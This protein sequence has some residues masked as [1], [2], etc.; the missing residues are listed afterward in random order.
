LFDRIIHINYYQFWLKVPR[1]MKQWFPLVITRFFPSFLLHC[2]LNINCFLWNSR[3]M[4]KVVKM[5]QLF[6]NNEWVIMIWPVIGF[7]I[8]QLHSLVIYLFFI[9]WKCSM[10]FSS[11]VTYP[12]L[13]I[14]TMW[15]SWYNSNILV[16]CRF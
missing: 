3:S 5:Q 14:L 15:I 4:H 6:N 9:T 2:L 1:K 7:K 8:P 10:K 13:V 12:P 16:Y 11:D